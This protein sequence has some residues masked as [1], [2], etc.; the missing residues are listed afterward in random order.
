MHGIVT[1]QTYPQRLVKTNAY[2]NQGQITPTTEVAVNARANKLIPFRL[3]KAKCRIDWLN[4]A[5]F[6]CI[7]Y[8]EIGLSQSPAALALI[9]LVLLMPK[10]KDTKWSA[11]IRSTKWS[12]KQDLTQQSANELSLCF[13]TCFVSSF[14]S[15]CC[16][17]ASKDCRAASLTLDR[18][19]RG[20]SSV[21]GLNLCRCCSAH[22][23]IC[24]ASAHVL[25]RGTAPGS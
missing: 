11:S 24:N 14:C 15:F 13:P 19:R 9:F 10:N 2:L 12:H 6:V 18:L 21:S 23:G 22:F 3:R 20:C 16:V 8:G 7:N 25:T 17:V 1:S 5:M 4:A